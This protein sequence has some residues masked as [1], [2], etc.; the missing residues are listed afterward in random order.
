MDAGTQRLRAWSGLVL[1]GLFTLGFV[2]AGFLPPPALGTSAEQMRQVLIENRIRIGLVLLL[3]GAS[4][5]TSSCRVSRSP[6]PSS[7]TAERGRSSRVGPRISTSGSHCYGVFA[8]WVPLVAFGSWFLVM[9]VL[10]LRAIRD[11]EEEL[12][13]LPDDVGSRV[14]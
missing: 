6:W 5:P 10:L 12:V 8:F 3:F 7:G 11:H 4:V 14:A 13:A 1:M 9:T 2:V